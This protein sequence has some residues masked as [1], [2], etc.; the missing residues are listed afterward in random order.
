MYDALGSKLQ[1]KVT[2]M[3]N[4]LITTT[5]YVN[6]HIYT[7]ALTT[8]ANAIPSTRLEYILHEEGRIRSVTKVMYLTSR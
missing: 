4:G 3:I 6:G 8:V 2:D 1:K 7:T 5:D